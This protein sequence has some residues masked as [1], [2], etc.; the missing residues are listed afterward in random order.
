[1]QGSSNNRPSKRRSGRPRTAEENLSRT[2]SS[3]ARKLAIRIGEIDAKLMTQGAQI[4]RLEDLFSSPNQFK[5]TTQMAT[6]GE[7]YRVLKKETLSLW[8]EWEKLSSEAEEVKI[9]L[10]QLNAK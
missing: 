4:K 1:M 10:G 5:D 6:S 2:L 3:Q 7:Q 9:Q 8:E